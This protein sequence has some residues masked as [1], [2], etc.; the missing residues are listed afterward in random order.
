MKA[1]CSGST[2]AAP[3]TSATFSWN[4]LLLISNVPFNETD[5]GVN[6]V[7]VRVCICVSAGDI[8]LMTM[9]NYVHSSHMY[10]MTCMY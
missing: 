10:H 2:T 3:I 6:P 9:C 5:S 1:V 8:W 4:T 7:Y